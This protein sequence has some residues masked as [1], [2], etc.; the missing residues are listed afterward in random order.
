MARVPYLPVPDIQPAGPPARAYDYMHIEAR[1]EAFGAGVGAA[2]ERGGQQIQEGGDAL[3]RAA[4]QRQNLMNQINADNATNEYQKQLLA[5]QYGDPTTGQKGFYSLNGRDAMD[6]YNGVVKAVDDARNQVRGTL[7]N[8]FQQREFDAAS[9]RMQ[10]VTLEQMAR[11]YNDQSVKYGTEVNTG[12]IDVAMRGIA[13]NYNDDSAFS[14]NLADI[15][16]AIIRNGQLNGAPD[17]L[18][19]SKLD[20]A[21]AQAIGARVDAWSSV[22]PAS[23]LS[24]LENNKQ[25][26][27]G[28]SYNRRYNALTRQI[29]TNGAAA[30][31]NGAL[32][33]LDNTYRGSSGVSYP[34][35]LGN[36]K[37]PEG[38]RTGT[39]QF[40]NPATP[41]DGA[42]LAANNLRSNYKGMTLAQIGQKWE[43]TTSQNVNNWIAN[44]SRSSGIAPNAV[45]NLDDP[46]Q[47]SAL[48]RGIATAEKT[49]NDKMRFTDDVINQGVQKSV[50]GAPVNFTTNPSATTF[51]TKADFYRANLPTL[52]DN[53]RA[54]LTQQFPN[55]PA[56]VEKGVSAAETQ[57]NKLIK[58]QDDIY[59]ADAHLIQSVVLKNNFTS[60]DQL[61]AYS[62][63]VKA[64]WARLQ[65]EL[66]AQARSLEKIMKENAKSTTGLGNGFS[67]A[68]NGIY[69][70][71]ITSAQQLHDLVGEPNGLTNAGLA[72][73]SKELTDAQTP[74][75]QGWNAFKTGFFKWAFHQISGTDPSQGRFDPKGDDNFNKFLGVALPIIAQQRA[76]GKTPNQVGETLEA[77][78]EQYALTESDKKGSRYKT[79]GDS[80]P[81]SFSPTGAVAGSAQDVGQIVGS[82][83]GSETPGFDLSDPH[84]A[85]AAFLHGSIDRGRLAAL[86][87]QHPEWAQA[88]KPAL[89]SAP[90][91]QSSTPQTQIR[92][93]TGDH[94]PE[95]VAPLPGVLHLNVSIS[96]RVP[97]G[98]PRP[99]AP[100]EWL[101][102]PDGSWS[103][104]RTVT[105]NLNGKWANVPLL[106]IQDGKPVL[107]ASDD[108]AAR[109]AKGS[110]L[111]WRT[112]QSEAAANQAAVDREKNWQ[113]ITP[114]QAR[115]V[116]P[117]WI[118]G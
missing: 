59:A 65:D 98:S 63:D 112:Y 113:G 82:A 24:F 6:G 1:P 3:F 105:V 43:G 93:A 74:Q 22:D 52:L 79:F 29:D 116:A 114:Q 50:S 10:S 2:L 70:G 61:N 41:Q 12:T 56:L 35:N 4:M 107:A 38:A 72:E 11:H 68:V 75:G 26:L 13:S 33:D 110:G 71:K 36:V 39:A 103:S 55:D 30:L 90:L 80:P 25:H 101:D 51:Q 31:V 34:N 60:D 14:N 64:A 96:P 95:N 15:H 78:V 37:T 97:A 106:W 47:L 92:T 67:A 23:A 17:Q 66:P 45:P 69:T 86:I 102:N 111:K 42:A 104:E 9:R 53:V 89:P 108:E 32:T 62:P 46:A 77:T 84:Q 21:D 88:S 99:L 118:G 115:S 83:A 85:A 16:R 100:G 18:T 28:P 54:R 94:E 81:P 48:L 44:V 76:E 5:L 49:P 27:D 40:Q 19:K 87:A 7:Q 58:Q 91:S 8:G 20:E 57:V 73:A 109:L 117:L